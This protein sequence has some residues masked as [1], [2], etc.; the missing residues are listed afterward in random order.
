VFSWVRFTAPYI[1]ETV[2]SGGLGAG[3]GAR[4]SSIRTAY[5]RRRC[6]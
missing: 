6:S 3:G 4:G 2:Y 1:S 5:A